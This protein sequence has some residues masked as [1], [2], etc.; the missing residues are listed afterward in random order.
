MRA[1]ILG[2]LA[3]MAVMA[4]G[5]GAPVEPQ[6]EN[7]NLATQSAPIP[8]CSGSPDTLITYWSDATYTVQI[9]GR[10]CYCG[11]WESWGKTSIYSQHVNDC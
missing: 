4:V 9:G 1:T 3:T 7:S 8:D 10:G 2:V 6:E 5:C 11:S